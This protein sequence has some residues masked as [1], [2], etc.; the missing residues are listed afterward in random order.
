MP[1]PSEPNPPLPPP[2]DPEVS[3]NLARMT[4]RGLAI[5]AGAVTATLL[6]RRWLLNQPQEG[7]IPWPIRRVLR[8]DER[9]SREVFDPR[10]LAPTFARAKGGTPRITGRYGLDPAPDLVNYRLKVEGPGGTRSFRLD[11][12][13]ALPRVEMTTEL[14]CIEGWS[15][16]VN[17]S[18]A[19]LADL[20][21]LCGLA[22]RDPAAP[23]SAPCDYAA[24]ET[25]G[26]AYYVGLEILA[27]LHP[28][29]L[30]C[31]AI[32]GQPLNSLHGAPLR[33]AIPLKYGIKHIKNIG[34]IRFTDVRPPDFWANRGYDWYSGH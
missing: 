2:T 24:L 22:L 12:I 26:G 16:I 23:G 28:Q 10:T 27:A 17:W 15:S 33:L 3:R 21:D 5:A 30:L 25:P 14:K 19:R 6:G 29:T 13:K 20:A 31:Y 8:F 11:Q 9:L 18:G 34:S 4:R 1:K 7:L 32:D